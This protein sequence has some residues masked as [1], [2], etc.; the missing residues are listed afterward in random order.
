MTDAQF[1]K[2]RNGI[3]TEIVLGGM[4]GK[5]GGIFPKKISFSR[6][7]NPNLAD[8]TTGIQRIQVKSEGVVVKGESF[9]LHMTV[10]NTFLT[11]NDRP[12]NGTA[13]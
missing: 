3:Q 1:V 7:K 2:E 4:Y 12:E 8:F 10:K 9:P 6:R 13:I 11:V 5:H